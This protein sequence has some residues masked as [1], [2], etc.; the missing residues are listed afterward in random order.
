MAMHHAGTGTRSLR[1]L[2]VSLL[3]SLI[4]IPDGLAGEWETLRESY[5]TALKAQARRIAEIE[6]RERGAPADQE[7]RAERITRA[8]ITDIEG[9]TKGGGKARSLAEAARRAPGDARAL[10][11]VSREQAEYLAVVMSEWTAE[12]TERRKLR[13]SIAT[14]QKNLDRVSTSLARSIEIAET[15]TMQVPESG[16]PAKIARME[17]EAKARAAWQLEQATRERER[18]QRERE[19][20]ERERRG[21]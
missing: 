16:V 19:A 20:A 5:D 3:L 12:G 7:K 4:A 14:L 18:Q 13:E 2:V 8:R 10:S 17:E 15:T 1:S 9:S 21:R 6:A 11:D